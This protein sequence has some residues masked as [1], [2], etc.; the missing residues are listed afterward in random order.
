MIGAWGLLFGWVQISDRFELPVV[1]WMMFLISQFFGLINAGI[2][3][4][5]YQVKDK[6]KTLRMVAVG[7]VFKIFNYVFM[8]N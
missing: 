4:Y 5:R 3:V 2:A 8:L 6:S 1:L 7:N